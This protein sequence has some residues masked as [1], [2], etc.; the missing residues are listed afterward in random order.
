L[1]LVLPYKYRVLPYKCSGPPL[2]PTIIVNCCG[3]MAVIII[4][5]LVLAAPA[6]ARPL[7]W[8]GVE[9]I[10]LGAIVG[11]NAIDC[12]QTHRITVD[13][14]GKYDDHFEMN[15]FT[16]ALFGE[17]VRWYESAA[18]KAGIYTPLIYFGCHKW[19]KSRRMRK[20]ILGCLVLVSIEPVIRNEDVSGGL[21]F[22][23]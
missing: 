10:M 17:K 12:Y 7:T 23:F 11:L 9:K 15:A 20:L 14:K 5:G 19:P 1:A 21:I 18:M 13:N 8:D 4:I 6:F 22:Q 16:K 3:I 2:E